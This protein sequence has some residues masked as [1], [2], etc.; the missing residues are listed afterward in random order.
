MYL[1]ASI[2]LSENVSEVVSS[3]LLQCFHL[4]KAVFYIVK[5][6]RQKQKNTV[7]PPPGKHMNANANKNHYQ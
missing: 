7:H 1:M 2:S 6:K 4:K 5:G 3:S